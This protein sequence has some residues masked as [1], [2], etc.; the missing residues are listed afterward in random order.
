MTRPV[1]WFGAKAG[2]LS[3]VQCRLLARNEVPD[4]LALHQET[5]GDLDSE[6]PG[7]G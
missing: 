2:V 7:D 4:T 5:N 1:G 3:A 6:V